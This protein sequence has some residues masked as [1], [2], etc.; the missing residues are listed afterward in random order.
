MRHRRRTLTIS[1]TMVQRLTAQATKHAPVETGGVLLGLH[2]HRRR[3]ATV[4]ELV[5]AGPKAKR[6]THRFDPDGPWQSAQIA[7]LYE[8]SGRALHYLGDWHS[9]PLGGKP[10]PLDRATAKRIATTQAARCPDPIFLIL[11]KV[12][13]DWKPRAYRFAKR[14]FRRIKVRVK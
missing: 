6:E 12:K 5:D 9:H 14:R 2:D 7:K 3:H 1:P 11:T 13:D 8:D 10:S 4:T